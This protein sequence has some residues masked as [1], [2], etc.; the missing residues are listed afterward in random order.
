MKIRQFAIDDLG[1]VLEIQ[2]KC[3][4]AAH[5]PE[6]DWLRLAKD[7]A[8]LV[9]IA[10]LET[11]T[12]P[13]IVGFAALHRVIDEAELR[14]LA[15]DPEHQH[16]GVAK[17]LLEEARRRMLVQGARRIFL[18]VRASNAPALELYYSVGFGLHSLRKDYY[19]DPQEDGYVL[20][21]KIFPPAVVATLS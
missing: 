14:N 4:N 20:S 6:S 16:Q 12:S 7:A 13:K 2:G 3:P 9:L 17:A 8:G 1:S 19:R 18:E 10:E 11:A 21:L 15:V 5:W